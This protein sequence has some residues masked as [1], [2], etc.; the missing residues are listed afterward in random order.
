MAARFE[1]SSVSRQKECSSGRK[2]N[3]NPALISYRQFLNAIGTNNGL[4]GWI[5]VTN[6]LH[7]KMEN[8]VVQRSE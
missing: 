7:M 2:A 4:G 3:I 6:S 5:V 8:I 1:E